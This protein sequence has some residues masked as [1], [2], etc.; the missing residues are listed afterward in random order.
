[1]VFIDLGSIALA[2]VLGDEIPWIA[3][4]TIFAGVSILV[5]A[6]FSIRAVIN[7]NSTRIMEMHQRFNQQVSDQLEKESNLKTQLDCDLYAR[8]YLNVVDGIAFLYKQRTIPESFVDYFENY[9]S[10]GLTILE[11]MGKHKLTV[12]TV[13]AKDTWTDL[14][15][16]CE[17]Y[18]IKE[19]KEDQLPLTMQKF[20][21]LPEE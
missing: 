4:G 10:Y 21:E 2:T 20:N 8:T 19:L 14:Q 12:G 6:Y 11:W 5:S 15:Y 18:N 16:L 7:T 13:I 3:A 9:F 1:M 17:M